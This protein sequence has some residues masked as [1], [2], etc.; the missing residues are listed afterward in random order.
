MAQTAEAAASRTFEQIGVKL[1]WHAGAR[2]CAASNG[3]VITLVEGVPADEHP[4]ALAYAMP[5]ERTH[6]IVF[7]D[8]VRGRVGSTMRPTLLAY[9]MAHEIAHILQGI[10]RHSK[11]G[12]MKQQWDHADYAEMANRGLRFTDYDSQFIRDNLRAG[13]RLIP[14]SRMSQG[15]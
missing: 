10:V 7:L 8:R 3:I 4:G 13:A 14:R 6:I 9:V 12:I 11:S 1:Q 15:L 5:Y 2:A